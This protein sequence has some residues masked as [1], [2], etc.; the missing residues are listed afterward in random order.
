MRLDYRKV[1]GFGLWRLPRVCVAQT[2]FAVHPIP[3]GVTGTHTDLF[4]GIKNP[5]AWTLCWRRCPPRLV[6]FVSPQIFRDVLRTKVPDIGVPAKIAAIFEGP[7]KRR[8]KFDV[9]DDHLS[10]KGGKQ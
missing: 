5:T 10:G 1:V 4:P 8:R 9:V 2:V 7:V 6:G 3:L